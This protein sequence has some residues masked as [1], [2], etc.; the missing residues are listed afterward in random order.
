MPGTALVLV[1]IQNDF[2]PP[3]GSLAVTDGR[4]ILPV[5]LDL[6]KD[7]SRFNVIVATLVDHPVG[8]VSFASTHGLKPFTATQVPKLN[9]ENETI[10][11]MLWPDHCVQNTPGCDIESSIQ[12][13]LDEIGD[14]FQYI[15]K[16]DDIAVDAYSGFADN[17]YMHITGLAKLLYTKNVSKVL[18]TGLAT[19]YCVKFTAIDACKFGFAT[20]V[21]EEAVRGVD[22]TADEAVFAELKKWG[23]QVIS[24]EQASAV[25]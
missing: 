5:V 19:D 4:Q 11:Q 1:D 8:H 6:L 15:K 12:K 17:Q 10:T 9:S 3:D 25:I 23:C 20:Y 7:P 22:P 18:V 16:G 13:R 2:L 24:L 14:K 21:V